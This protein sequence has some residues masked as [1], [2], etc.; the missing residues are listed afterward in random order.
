VRA[1]FALPA[2]F[3]AVSPGNSHRRRHRINHRAWPRGHWVQLLE[4]LPSD[5]PIVVLGARGEEPLAALVDHLPHR[6]I[7]LTGQTS[8]AE[9][10]TIVALARG[11]VVTDTGPA[12]VA[13]AVNTPVVCLIG[14]TAAAVT[15]PYATA[16]N[17]VRTLSVGLPCAPCHDTPAM[18]ACTVNRCMLQLSPQAVLHALEHSGILS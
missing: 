6:V 10:V 4:L 9:L 17:V 8:I 2:T 12:H 14:P 1:R 7:D 3:L 11:L 5:L 13:A 16:H 15:G 18:R